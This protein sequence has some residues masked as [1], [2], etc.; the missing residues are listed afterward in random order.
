M[1]PIAGV[2]QQVR[3]I[4]VASKPGQHRTEG[5]S[6][7]LAAICALLRQSLKLA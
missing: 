7:A 5:G 1:P 2:A 3:K 4:P 6:R